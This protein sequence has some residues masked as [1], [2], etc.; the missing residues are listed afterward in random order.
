LSDTTTAALRRAVLEH[1]GRTPGG[2]SALGDAV[3]LVVAEA[4]ER[5]MRA[6]D[7]ILAFKAL[8]DALPEPGSAAAR[9]EQLR[10]RE[11]LVTACIN[12]YYGADG[13]GER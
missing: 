4:R 6:E 7:L 8:Y 10:L 13:P 9:A 3:S 12:A 1:L 5:Q 2:D 11:R